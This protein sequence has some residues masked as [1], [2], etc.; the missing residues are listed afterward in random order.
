MG[1]QEGWG[2][3]SYKSW[4]VWPGA[5][6]SP[7]AAAPWKAPRGPKPAT[8]FPAYDAQ[9]S[10]DKGGG[11]GWTCGKHKEIIE[12]GGGTTGDVQRALN[13][14]KKAEHRLSRL[15]QD[16]EKATS[17]WQEYAKASRAAYYKEKERYLK[18][19]QGYDRD[20]Q[21]AQVAQCEA[22][23]AL[24][25]QVAGVYQDGQTE[26]VDCMET[27]EDGEW[28]RMIAD[29]EVESALEDDAVLRRAFRE[30]Q[31]ETRGLRSMTPVRPVLRRDWCRL[32]QKA[33]RDLTSRCT[34]RSRQPFAE[35]KSIRTRLLHHEGTSLRGET[36]TRKL[37]TARMPAESA[38]E[39][40]RSTR[41]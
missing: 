22:R 17:Q 27:R 41:D 2:N 1:K 19:L 30:A 12:H 24:R 13:A 10:S 8:K 38:P 20:V 36:G 15:V 28:E 39:P 33:K 34:M 4:Q 26:A 29:Y 11:K 23:R 37:Q 40:R 9:P 31:M 3:G 18:A 7:K 14:T 25:D 21:E 6:A 16:R 32:G 35:R 5:Y